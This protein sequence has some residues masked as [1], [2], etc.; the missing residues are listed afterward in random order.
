MAKKDYR[1]VKWG[2]IGAGEFGM[3]Y[4]HI[5][6]QLPNVDLVSVYSRNKDN[7]KKAAEACDIPN[8]YDDYNIRHRR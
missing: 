5:L 4:A 1:R 8:W 3:L 7:A 2:L 6:K